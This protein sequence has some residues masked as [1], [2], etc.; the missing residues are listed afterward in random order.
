LDAA[1][2]QDAQPALKAARFDRATFQDKAGFVGATF[3]DEAHF[4]GRPS[5]AMPVHRGDLPQPG[6][7]REDNLQEQAEFSSRSARC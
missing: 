4:A 5:G 6:Q 2:H 1:P 7:V 3:R